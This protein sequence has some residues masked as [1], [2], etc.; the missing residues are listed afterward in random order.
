MGS[1]DTF[2]ETGGQGRKN[3]GSGI[4]IFDLQPKIMRLEGT[5]TRGGN[6]Y[7]RIRVFFIKGTPPEIEFGTILILCNFSF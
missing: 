6:N 2:L 5:A 4:L 1:C 3:V 7:F